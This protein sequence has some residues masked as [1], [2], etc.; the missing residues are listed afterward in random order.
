MKVRSKLM[1]SVLGMG[2]LFLAGS[3]ICTQLGRARLRQIVVRAT[4]R[5]SALLMDTITAGLETYIRHLKLLAADLDVNEALVESNR[6]F[7][8]LQDVH[9]HVEEI[10][11]KWVAAPDDEPLPLA[12]ELLA[13]RLS[14]E[15]GRKLE[16]GEHGEIFA[17]NEYG[18]TAAMTVVTTD[19]FQADEVWWQEAKSAGT[20]VGEVQFDDSAKLVGFPL[21]VSVQDD[22]G[23]FL[24]VLKALLLPK[25]LLAPLRGT[26]GFPRREQAHLTL[27]G[28]EGNEI[29]TNNKGKAKT[30]EAAKRGLPA[31]DDMNPVPGCAGRVRRAFRPDCTR[32]Y[33]AVRPTRHPAKHEGK[34]AWTL[35]ATR[36]MSELLA[37]VERVQN[38][39]LLM[40][41]GVTTLALF[42][43][44]ALSTGLSR[45]IS[46]LRKVAGEVGRGNLR[47]RAEPGSNDELGALA[48]TF[49][50]MAAQLS[51]SHASLERK[52]AERT[53][54]L[55]AEIAK[56]EEA[57]KVL[58]KSEA[59]YRT[60]TNDVLDT[61]SVGV[62]ILSPEFEVVW[63]NQ[64]LERYFGLRREEI[65][66]KDK[67]QLIR[68]RIKYTFEDP[69]RFAQ[70]VFATYDNNTYSEDFECHVLPAEGRK[71]RWLEHWSQPIT[72]GL[73]AG[74][75][76]EHYSDVTDRKQAA[77]E[78]QRHAEELELLNPKLE[79]SN[80][81]LQEFTYAASHDLQEPL[82]K[83]HAFAQFLVEDCGDDISE[84]G[85]D[86]LQRMQSATVRMKDLIHHLLQ[87]SRV[88][89]RG[90]EL[91][92]VDPAKILGEVT[93]TLSEALRET[94]AEVE[95]QPDLPPVMADAI[96][97]RQVFQNLIDN[98][99]KFRSP[100]RKPKLHIAAQAE[101]K[102]VVFSVADNG[103]GI[104]ERF[105]EK[106]FGVFERL[107]VRDAYEGSG[108]GLALCRKIVQRH[109][110]R[111]WA[112]S[113]PGRGSTFY[114][115][116][117]PAPTERGEL[118]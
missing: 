89:T 79:Q 57:Q 44:L 78:L 105:L 92:P 3:Y 59:E 98:A 74:G 88:D 13:N 30:E 76:V 19:Y 111:I 58:A 12:R 69:E 15:L 7:R 100:D 32:L 41:V 53:T 51:E 37:P 21:A 35:V 70:K 22:E 82:R 95:I 45:C 75:R 39:L 17:T 14:R 67:R 85:R 9:A 23:R 42:L 116:L 27:L 71:E 73:Y 33:V 10:D 40:S 97:L 72:S 25:A 87:L 110:G 16:A 54:E 2:L 4:A 28:P 84:E 112:E 115:T 117:R 77:A 61:S 36:D 49:N 107:H 31:W 114:F 63:V 38:S 81:D 94:E 93:D 104:E 102:H 91:I 118:S 34:E 101:N 24:G 90:A 109:G 5:E 83:V 48:S 29:Y 99:L 80:R 6:R 47:A 96:Q 103:I 64:A 65:I 8:N 46:R 20:F 113:E 108:V 26:H 18:A 62:F 43:G 60:L 50:Q 11:R 52:V 55:T 68:E 56:R 1:L 106:I 66:G 86:Y